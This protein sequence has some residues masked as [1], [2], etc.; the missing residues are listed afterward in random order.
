LAELDRTKDSYIII[1][2]QTVNSIF[3]QRKEVEK[4]WNLTQLNF[5]ASLGVESNDEDLLKGLRLEVNLVMDGYSWNLNI[6][7]RY[8]EI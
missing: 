2:A 4:H 7:D 8:E 3:T 5:V 1:N 6:I